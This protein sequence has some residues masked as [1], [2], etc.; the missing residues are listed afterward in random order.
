[1]N[2]NQIGEAVVNAKYFT[3]VIQ[4]VEKGR[5]KLHI[6]A[7][8]RNR[9]EGLLNDL[10]T[11]F[12]IA[13]GTK[14]FTALAIARLIDAKKLS[15]DDKVF[16]ILPQD[17]PNMDKEVT[18]AHLLSHTSGI[19]DYFDEEVIEDFGQLFKVV[20]INEIN[21]PT[22]DYPLLIRGDAYFKPGDKF[23]YCNSG[24]VILGMLI[25]EV[26]GM[27]YKAF[28]NEEVIEPLGLVHTGCY[29]TNA[30]PKNTA[31]GYLEESDSLKSNIFEIPKACT[32]DGGLFTTADDVAKMWNGFIKGDLISKD[33]RDKM[34]TKQADIHWEDSENLGYGLG[35]YIQKE[36]SGEVKNYFLV[37]EDPGVS[38]SSNYYV[39]ED[40]IVTILGNTDEG[41]WKL[42]DEIAEYL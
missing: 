18:V 20:P 12:G 2:L 22:D 37:G 13:S 21:G 26:S 31:V 8:Y 25:E 33:L 16:E 35:F 36:P 14:G 32:A 3:G 5:L 7:G 4:I 38:F 17:F 30:L 10:D 34:L 19:Y 9:G 28:L 24:F 42:F 39:K 15:L 23:K 29:E 6:A 27:S 41:V 40:R 1:M 11:A